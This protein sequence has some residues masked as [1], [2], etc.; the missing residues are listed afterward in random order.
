M[1]VTIADKQNADATTDKKTP[2]PHSKLT[3]I[4]G[5]F[6]MPTNLRRLL[7]RAADADPLN[8][9]NA[10]VQQM[11]ADGTVIRRS[12]IC[13]VKHKPVTGIQPDYDYVPQFA[14]CLFC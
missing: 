6:T 7:A 14:T 4:S 12:K 13:P 1:K 3:L 11:I 5:D 9:A 10:D 2:L 8:T